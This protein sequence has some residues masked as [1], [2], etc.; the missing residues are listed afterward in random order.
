[1]NIKETAEGTIRETKQL[2]T[3]T[4]QLSDYLFSVGTMWEEEKNTVPTSD[5]G[6]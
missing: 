5:L 1:M 4:F 6:T 3:V 2:P